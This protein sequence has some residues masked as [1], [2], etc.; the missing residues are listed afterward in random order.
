MDVCHLDVL[1]SA[2]LSH[3]R[4]FEFMFLHKVG[5]P[6]RRV[7]FLVFRLVVQPLAIGDGGLLGER[8]N[9]SLHL[10]LVIELST[11]KQP[12]SLGDLSFCTV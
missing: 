4:R 5:L 8:H 2:G 12:L 1:T 6:D 9:L 11:N 7:S 3:P 10:K